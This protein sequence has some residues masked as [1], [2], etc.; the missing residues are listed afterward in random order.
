MFEW[1]KK[2]IEIQKD[3][4]RKEFTSPIMSFWEFFDENPQYNLL[5]YEHI[6]NGIRAIY[7]KK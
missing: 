6:P 3:F 7:T 4:T 5:R 2:R 1:L